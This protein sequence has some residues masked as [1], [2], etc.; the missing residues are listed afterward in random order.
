MDLDVLR[1]NKDKKKVA[2]NMISMQFGKDLL[3][4]KMPNGALVSK[5]MM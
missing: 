3:G 5:V 2:T 4:I 1:L